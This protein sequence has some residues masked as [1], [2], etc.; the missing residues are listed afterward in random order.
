MKK[1]KKK[2]KK[3]HNKN[4]RKKNLQV[5]QNKLESLLMKTLW[6]NS[7]SERNLI[8]SYFIPVYF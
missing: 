3:K 6:N 4:K 1:K 8:V 7:N 5:S 2:K